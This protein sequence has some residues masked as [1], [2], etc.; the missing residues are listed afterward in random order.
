MRCPGAIRVNRAAVTVAALV[1]VASSAHAQAPTEPARRGGLLPGRTANPAPQF[2]TRDELTRQWDLNADG[3]IDESEA[4]MARAK[5]RRQRTEVMQKLQASPLA[6]PAAEMAADA[7]LADDTL[8]FPDP[9]ASPPKTA[10]AKPDTTTQKQPADDAGGK[11]PAPKRDLNAGRLPAGFPP[12]RG[13]PAGTPPPGRI[14]I[15]MPG[16]SPPSAT[17]GVR[18]GGTLVPPTTPPPARTTRQP[19]A[20]RPVPAVPARP[21]VTAEEIGGQ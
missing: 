15:A 8:M 3:T 20:L 19:P 6:K 18:R 12:A 2:R 10:A 21:R 13:I 5:M 11:P 7:D 17:T 14:G 1:F 9:P 4:E 16:Q